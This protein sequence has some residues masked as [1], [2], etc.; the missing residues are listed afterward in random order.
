MADIDDTSL[1]I[2]DIP[3][4]IEGASEDKGLGDAFLRHIER[5]AVLLHLIDAYSDDVALAYQTIREELRRYSPALLDHPEVVAL[6]KIEGL[7]ADMIAMQTDA[8]TAVVAASTPIFAISSTAHTG[9]T[10]LLRTL[11]QL[12][13]SGTRR[14]SRGD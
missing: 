11:A 10:E 1:L 13:A 9:L 14:Q 5:S 8:L 3:G 4:L 12:V 6:T 2:A 7:D